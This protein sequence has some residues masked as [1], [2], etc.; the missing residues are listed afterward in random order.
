[1]IVYEVR[2]VL[3]SAIVD[4]Y[5][6]WLEPHIREVLSVGGFLRAELLHEDADGTVVFVVRFHVDTRETLMAYLRDHA[7]RL[8]EDAVARF[9]TQ[10]TTT[11]R[12]HELVRAFP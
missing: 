1:V 3:E 7:P 6:A 5:R 10:F 11:R 12:V 2:I 9:G 4:T 8:R